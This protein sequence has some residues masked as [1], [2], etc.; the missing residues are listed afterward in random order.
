MRALAY[1]LITATMILAGCDDDF[2][3]DDFD[4]D[5]DE[6]VDEDVEDIVDEANDEDGEFVE[7]TAIITGFGQY[8]NLSGVS[9]VLLDVPDVFDAEIL[10][11]S[12]VPGLVRPWHVHF[13]NCASGGAIVGPPEAYRALTVGGDGTAVVAAQIASPFNLAGEYHVNV[14]FSPTD[15]TV[16]ACGDLIFTSPEVDG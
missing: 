13:G 7:F 12:D 15:Q 11:R 9:R 16:I 10:I 14:H 5:I 3:D 6:S 2:F 4:D 8:S 1:L